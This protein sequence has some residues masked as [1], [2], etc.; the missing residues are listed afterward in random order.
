[1]YSFTED[2]LRRTEKV[3][4]VVEGGGDQRPPHVS[5]ST[6]N[7]RAPERRTSVETEHRANDC[8]DEYL[9]PL[10]LFHPLQLRPSFIAPLLMNEKSS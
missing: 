6:V 4:S 8:K 1:M 10:Q 9:G 2:E 5:H 7:R 3:A